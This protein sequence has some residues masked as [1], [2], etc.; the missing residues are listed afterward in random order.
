LLG[1]SFLFIDDNVV[2]S[3]LCVLCTSFVRISSVSSYAKP[4][5]SLVLH[6][7]MP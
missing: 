5:C 3:T 4:F 2:M 7:F 1:D 6:I